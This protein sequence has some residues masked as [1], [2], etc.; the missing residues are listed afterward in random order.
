M[1]GFCVR[2]S[3]FAQFNNES[4]V[5]VKFARLY[6]CGGIEHGVEK[7]IHYCFRT[8]EEVEGLFQFIS[9]FIAVFH[10]FIPM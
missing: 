1:S 4:L 8:V 10:L 9:F 6:F 2:V 7:N 3:S 5:N